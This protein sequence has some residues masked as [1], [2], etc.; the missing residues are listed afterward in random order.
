MNVCPSW[1]TFTSPTDLCIVA[2]SGTTEVG[3]T[4]IPAKPEDP[5]DTADANTF[6]TMIK[7]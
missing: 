2:A 4:G 1:H 7:I 6:E 5:T 3:H